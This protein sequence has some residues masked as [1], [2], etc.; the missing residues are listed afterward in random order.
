MS[1]RTLRSASAE[2]LHR[3]RKQAAKELSLPSTDWRCKRYALLMCAHDNATA[4]LANGA[5][6]N[7]DAL[8]RL[9]S[10]MA[11]VRG[12]VPPEPIRVQ[13]DVVNPTACKCPKC[14][15]V[16]DPE[17]PERTV[18]LDPP[19]DPDP[20][21]AGP[22]TLPPPRETSPAPAAPQ[23][24][25]NVVPLRK[26]SK[27]NAAPLSETMR[28]WNRLQGYSI[29]PDGRLGKGNPRGGLIW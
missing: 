7:V 14:A 4:R 2:R 17:S 28:A 1:K 27:S 25:G 5:D 15:H 9:D 11:E 21:P 12:S 13:I 3:A 22:P 20:P 29:A 8:L 19:P 6:I 24:Q 23:P 16:F 18:M 26:A 10:A